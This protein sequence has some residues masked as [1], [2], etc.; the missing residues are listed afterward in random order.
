[1]LY[2]YNI[3]FVYIVYIIYMYKYTY[4]QCVSKFLIFSSDSLFIVIMTKKIV[5]QDVQEE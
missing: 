4:I 5:H 1:M 3:L 2:V